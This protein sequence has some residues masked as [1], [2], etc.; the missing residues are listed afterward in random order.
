MSSVLFIAASP[1]SRSRSSVLLSLAADR[2]E[3][4]GLAAR[5]LRLNEL[6]AQAALQAD[7]R[8][9]RIASALASVDEAQ[10]VVIATP[11]Y[12]AS[13]SGLL[14]VFLD[15]L[16]QDGLQGKVVWALA[17]A[18]SPAHLLAL[19][20]A[21]QPVLTALGAQRQVE[22]VYATESQLLRLPSGDYQP[23]DD[24][25]WRIRQGA[26]RMAELMPQSLQAG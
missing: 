17:S 15:L 3:Q 20:Y 19:D 7:F 23:D 24:I 4:L 21:L 16:P 26:S 10:A 11:I 13:Y 25:L 2:L 6:P 22:G 14:K 1:S 9:P 18:G 5:W 12:K 8:H